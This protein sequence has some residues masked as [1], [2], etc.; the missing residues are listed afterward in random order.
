MIITKEGFS[1]EF[2]N[3]YW[4]NLQKIEMLQRWIIVQS[5]I[6]YEMNDSVVSDSMYDNNVL[7]LVEMMEDY[8]K[9]AKLSRYKK[10]FHDFD[11]STGYHLSYR[12]RGKLKTFVEMQAASVVA[13]THSIRNQERGKLNVSS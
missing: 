5:Y 1:L 4:T 6:Y 10:I 9:A 12:L 11:G 3:P 13:Y 7:Q 2:R 8:P